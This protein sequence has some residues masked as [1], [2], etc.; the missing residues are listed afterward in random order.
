[1]SQSKLNLEQF[2]YNEPTQPRAAR[3]FA[4]ILNTALDIIERE[5]IDALNTNKIAKDCGINISTLYH[6]FPNKDSIVYA[7]YQKWFK[8]VSEITRNQPLKNNTPKRQFFHNIVE[9]ILSIE[10]Y[11][12][13]AAVALEQAIKV[14]SELAQYDEHIT[15]LSVTF[16]IDTLISLKVDASDEELVTAGSFLSIAV[17]GAINI[18][19]SSSR[20]DYPMIC[21]YAANMMLAIV[22]R[23]KTGS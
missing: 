16:Y 12:P 2:S 6:Y 9:G 18:A 17:W 13:K 10:D 5:G 14:R 21:D 7:L 19:A 11:S 8:K 3:T 1:M 15:E 23:A 22:K 4:R 20:K